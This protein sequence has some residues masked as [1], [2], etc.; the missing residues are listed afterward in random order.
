VSPFFNLY[1]ET[2]PVR[3]VRHN[4]PPAKFVFAGGEDGRLGV[5]LDSLVAPGVI[6]SGGQVERSILGSFGRVNSWARVE[7]SILMDRVD[8]GRR[9]VV[10]RAI[11]D[12]GVRIP[13]GMQ[14]GVDLE[15]DRKRFLV[16]E[17]GLVVIP[18]GER[19]D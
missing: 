14:I 4:A 10:R 1:D 11:V 18:R 6:V 2:W 3:T 5:A 13:S 8:V 17:G 15:E 12:K 9:A 7:D 16:T 19:L